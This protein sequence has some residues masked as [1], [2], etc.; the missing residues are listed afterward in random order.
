MKNRVSKDSIDLKNEDVVLRFQAS[1]P[2][3]VWLSR[4]GIRECSML[5]ESQIDY[6]IRA[7]KKQGLFRVRKCRIR[8]FEYRLVAS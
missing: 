6:G 4:D 5:S 2:R 8:A 3:G 1:I 7:L